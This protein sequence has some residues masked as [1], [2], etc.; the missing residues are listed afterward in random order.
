MHFGDLSP[1]VHC[2]LHA[3]TTMVNCHVHLVN[4]GS[5]VTLIRVTTLA[6]LRTSDTGFYGDPHALTYAILKP[7]RKIFAPVPRWFGNEVN[8]TLLYIDYSSV[9]ILLLF[10]IKVILL[11]HLF[12]HSFTI[13]W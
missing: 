1:Y 8:H 6:E 13:R 12:S 11:S 3:Y 9:D 4:A 5:W 2:P 7:R 10:V